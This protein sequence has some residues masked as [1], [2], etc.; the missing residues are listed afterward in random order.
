MKFNLF[1]H[2]YK[3]DVDKYDVPILD[4]WGEN[5]VFKNKEGKDVYSYID[6]ESNGYREVIL[7]IST[8]RGSFG[9]VHFYGRLRSYSLSFTDTVE[10]MGK[11][12]ISGYFTSGIPE[13]YKNFFNVQLLRPITQ[14]DIDYDTENN[15]DRWLNYYIGDKTNGFWTEDEVIEVGIKVFKKLFKGK[16]QLR[17]DSYSGN[18]D[19]IIKL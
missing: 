16:W 15:T 14:K 13:E 8:F 1:N 2:I 4:N 11:R 18:R 3:S 12:S 19:K 10:S 9:A 5:K 6:K 7:D 17:I